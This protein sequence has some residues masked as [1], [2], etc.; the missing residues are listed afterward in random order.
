MAQKK[1]DNGNGQQHQSAHKGADLHHGSIG[2]SFSGLFGLWFLLRWSCGLWFFLR[3]G[4]MLIVSGHDGR[5][6]IRE[7]MRHSRQRS[8]FAGLPSC[9]IAS[10]YSLAPHWEQNAEPDSTGWPQAGQ[11]VGAEDSSAVGCFSTDSAG[12]SSV[13]MMQLLSSELSDLTKSDTG[14]QGFNLIVKAGNLGTVG[15]IGAFRLGFT[16]LIGLAAQFQQGSI[17]I[18][19]DT[20]DFSLELGDLAEVFGFI[21]SGTGHNRDLFT[22]IIEKMPYDV[23][24]WVDKIFFVIG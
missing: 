18:G 8:C 3:R 19:L 13:L 22:E 6:D 20:E 16:L 4:S 21:G 12:V 9:V 15:S 1:I 14:A 5:R 17:D 10:V 24:P 2:R 7:E 23:P 11:T